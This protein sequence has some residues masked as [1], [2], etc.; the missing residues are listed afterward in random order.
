MQAVPINCPLQGLYRVFLTFWA[1]DFLNTTRMRQS[2]AGLLPSIP[3]FMQETR[4]RS[5]LPKSS[6]D[7]GHTSLQTVLTSL[8]S[9]V[10][11]GMSSR[12]SMLWGL[13]RQMKEWEIIKSMFPFSLRQDSLNFFTLP[14]IIF[15]RFILYKLFHYHNSPEREPFGAP[16]FLVAAAPL[17]RRKWRNSS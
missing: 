17:L 15:Q 12:S 16:I 14:C 8:R 13:T 10:C 6:I 3:R 9:C 4:Q 1:D 5:D 7:V 2:K 11:Y